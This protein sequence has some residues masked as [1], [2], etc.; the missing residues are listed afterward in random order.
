MTTDLQLKGKTLKSIKVLKNAELENDTI[1]FLTTDDELYE[2]THYQDCCE[3]VY[4]DDIV[5]D[6]DDLIGNPLNMAEVSYKTGEDEYYESET[7]TFYK[8]GTVKG[9]VTIKWYGTSNGYYSEEASLTQIFDEP[10]DDDWVYDYED[11][12]E[13]QYKHIITKYFNE[14]EA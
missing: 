3:H 1:Y 8:F 12:Y 14:N 6:L 4:I 2:M 7:W 5:G 9:Y 10:A 13:T 11:N